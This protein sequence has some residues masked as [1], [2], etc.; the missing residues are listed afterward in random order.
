[1]LLRRFPFPVSRFPALLFLIGVSLAH[2][3]P[4]AAADFSDASASDA[5]LYRSRWF[6]FWNAH[7]GDDRVA[8]SAALAELMRPAQTSGS[9]VALDF[10]RTGARA[11]PC[12]GAG[13]RARP[14]RSRLPSPFSRWT[15][16]SGRAAF[17]R[18]LAALP[19]AVPRR[20]PRASHASRSFPAVPL[21]RGRPASRGSA[22][23]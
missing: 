4:C 14:A 10:A 7:L 21:G 6:E 5:G 1:M 15:S 13:T 20:L 2:G 16:T 23:L 12:G 17:R 19:A 22:R 18:R 9:S 8:A 11:A 3:G